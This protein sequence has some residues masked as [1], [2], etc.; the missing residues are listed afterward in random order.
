MCAGAIINARIPR[1]VFGAPD[2]KAGSCGSLADLFAMGYNHRPQVTRGILEDQCAEVLRTFFRDL[3]ANP[4]PKFW[5][6]TR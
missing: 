5:Q 6:K 4:V 1:V 3:R 2:P